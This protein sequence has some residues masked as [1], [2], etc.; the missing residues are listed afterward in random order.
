MTEKIQVTEAMGNLSIVKVDIKIRAG[1]R[2]SC[3]KAGSLHTLPQFPFGFEVEDDAGLPQ[4]SMT[5]VLQ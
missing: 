4:I 2:H 1:A 3:S 5:K